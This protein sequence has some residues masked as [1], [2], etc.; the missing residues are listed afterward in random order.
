MGETNKKSPSAIN[1]DRETE[2]TNSCTITELFP[3]VERWLTQIEQKMDM[4]RV[5]MCALA[6][7]M[8][9]D[10]KE[11]RRYSENKRKLHIKNYYI[12]CRLGIMLPQYIYDVFMM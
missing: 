11:R 6:K 1:A 10:R 4:Y 3:N 12:K 9:E 5:E 7:Q 8:E 2:E